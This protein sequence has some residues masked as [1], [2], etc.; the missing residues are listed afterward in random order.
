MKILK[1][2]LLKERQ[3]KDV[4]V[5]SKKDVEKE[6]ERTKTQLQEKVIFFLKLKFIYL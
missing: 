1:D 6:L 5:K 2:A 4:S 3:E